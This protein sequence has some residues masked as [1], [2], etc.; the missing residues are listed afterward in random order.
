MKHLF[1]LMLGLVLLVPAQAQDNAYPGR[2]TYPNVSILETEELRSRFNDVII[3]DVRSQYEY[4]T[5]HINNAVNVPLSAA[6]FIQRITDLQGSSNKPIVFYC[7]GHTCFK[8][9]KAVTRCSNA[10][11]H[12]VFAYDSG[13]FDWARANPD[14]AT[15]L[16]KTP[17]DSKRLISR[18]ELEKYL[19]DPKSFSARIS[20]KSVILD[21]REPR[22]RGLVELFPFRQENISMDD[23]K[24]LNSF[25]DQVKS[26]GKTLLVYDEAGKQVRWFQYYLVEKG[27]KD[28]YF[29]S[30]GVK[31]FF[32]DLRG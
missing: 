19:L 13:I 17:V 9:Y 12:N 3:V 6:D 20:D 2:T 31:Q 10:N 32:K 11:I 16:G 15:M 30:G 22:Q 5:L 14:M 4:D 26:S 8:S 21:I 23:R 24:R 27:I 25:L 28:Y 29:M 7:N 1:F 18:S